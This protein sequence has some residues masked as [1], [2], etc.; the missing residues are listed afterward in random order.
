MTAALFG[1]TVQRSFYPEDTNGLSVQIPSLGHALYLFENEPSYAEAIS[2]EGALQS[3]TA[4]SEQEEAAPYGCHYEFD[5][6]A[7]PSPESMVPCRGYW[8]ALYLTLEAGA[9]P[10]LIKRYLEVSRIKGANAVPGTTVDDL[11]AVFPDIGSY[12]SNEKLDKAILTAEGMLRDDLALMGAKWHTVVNLEQTRKALAYKAAAVACAGQATNPGDRHA[13]R[14][15]ILEGW[16]KRA[17]Q[18]VP[19]RFDSDGDSV[20]EAEKTTE[21]TFTFARR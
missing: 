13:A 12:A 20:P 5:P 14:F 8:E 1:K 16:Y 4:F 7:D 3:K 19:I 9:S 11:V 15:Q 6:I 17:M 18:A 2:G 10:V 21:R